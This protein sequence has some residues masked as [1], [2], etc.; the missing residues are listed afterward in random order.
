MVMVEQIPHIMPNTLNNTWAEQATTQGQ[1]RKQ[2]MDSTGNNI[3]TDT[4][5]TVQATVQGY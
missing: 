2:Y 3:W 5:W 1:Y 4:I